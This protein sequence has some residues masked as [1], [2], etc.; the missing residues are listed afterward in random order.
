VYEALYVNGQ[1]MGLSCSTVTA[2]KSKPQP[3]SVPA[4]LQPTVTQLQTIHPSWIDRFPFAHMR[5]NM[6]I[7]GTMI[8][9]EEFVADL[10][11]MPT[12]KIKPGSPSWD[13][14]AW[15]VEKEFADKWG[16]LLC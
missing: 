2:M 12:F 14:M 10:F 8:D 15:S 3:P 4:S 13:P 16:Y 11:T 5:D 9:D 1:I 6:I 7:L